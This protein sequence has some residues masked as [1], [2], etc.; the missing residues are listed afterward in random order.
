MANGGTN[1][2]SYASG[3]LLIGNSSNTLTKATLTEGTGI[4]ITNGN[5][6]I[7]I[8]HEDTSSLSGAQGGNG[9]A[10]FTLDGMGHVTAVTS[11]TYLTGGSVCAAIVDCPID[12]GTF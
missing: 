5:G 7:T 4:D 1:Q 6:S 8:T 10:A 11:A 3:E 9:I 12:G 2:T